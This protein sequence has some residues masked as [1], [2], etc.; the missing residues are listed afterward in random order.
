ML[1]TSGVDTDRERCIH[2]GSVVLL[3]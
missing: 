1:H 3:W 2:Y